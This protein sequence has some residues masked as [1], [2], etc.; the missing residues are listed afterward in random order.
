[1]TAVRESAFQSRVMLIGLAREAVTATRSRRTIYLILVPLLAGIGVALL[2][3]MALKLATVVGLS[4]TTVAVLMARLGRVLDPAWV[5]VAQLFM[6]QPI[7]VLLSDTGLA[8]SNLTTL[9]LA[10]IPFVLVTLVYFP[11]SRRSLVLAAPLVA[12]AIFATASLAWTP[13]GDYGAE[14]LTQWLATGMAP[15]VSILVLYTARKRV[16]WQLILAAAVIDA[17]ALLLIGSSAEYGGR[18]T[19]EGQNPIWVARGV[20]VGA[21]VAVLGP[22]KIWVKMVTV[23][24]L[25][26]AGGLTESLGPIVGLVF[27]LLAAAIVELVLN[28]RRSQGV[29]PWWLVLG[30]TTGFG[31][32]ILVSGTM[33]PLL[34]PIVADPNVA[35]RAADVEA[36]IP[37]FIG[38]PLFGTGIGGF[39]SAGVDLYPHNLLLEVAAELG[40]LG[41]FALVVWSGL[42]LMGASRRPMMMGLVVGTAMF[43]LFSGSIASNAEFWMFSALAVALAPIAMAA[44][45][46]TPRSGRSRSTV[47]NP[48]MSLTGDHQ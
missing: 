9:T 26:L 38:S 20:V 44:W 48:Q 45:P 24:V 7:A 31:L 3:T 16:S 17:I 25:L 42:A 21:L 5:I 10:F 14:K 36:S 11:S 30:L 13:S 19:L 39:A 34:G 8:I 46:A 1:M 32:I 15:A 40:L 4:A 22:F 23:P 33:D 43:A 35:S 47:R 12:I 6:I 28:G 18:L 2:P 27:G 41:S 29:S 37:L